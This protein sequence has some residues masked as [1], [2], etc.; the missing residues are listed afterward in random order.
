[1]FTRR[2][3]NNHSRHPNR[4]ARSSTAKKLQEFV[5]PFKPDYDVSKLVRI[6]HTREIADDD[7]ETTKQTIYIPQLPEDATPYQMLD[8]FRE[9]DDACETMTWTTG[10]AKFMKIKPH[11]QGIHKEVWNE[12]LDAVDGRSNDAF[13]EA[14]GIF[15]SETF[16]EVRDYDIQID[17]LRSIK[18]PGEMSVKCFLK[19]LKIANKQVKM[20]PGAPDDGGLTESEL[21]KTFLQAMPRQ[22]QAHYKNAGRIYHTDNI[23]SMRSYFD[24]QEADDPYVARSND[25][26]APSQ[27]GNNHH[28]PERN[29]FG[30]G[31]NNRNGRR[32]NGNQRNPNNHQV[33]RGQQVGG[34]GNERCYNFGHQGNHTVRECRRMR[35]LLRTNDQPNRTAIAGNNNNN[36]RYNLRPRINESNAVETTF[37]S[38]NQPARQV[39]HQVANPNSG[40][41]HSFESAPDL[42]HMEV[43]DMEPELYGLFHNSDNNSNATPT[44]PA[45]DL[46]PVT[47]AT[48]RKVSEAQGNFLFKALLD[49]GGSHVMV[50][51]A[52][53]PRDT[54]LY[55]DDDEKS[56]RT[57]QG[58]F[59]PLG[60]VY[61]YDLALPEF[62]HTRRFDTVKAYVFDAP[63]RYDII[64][65][66][67]FLRMANMKLD[68][69]KNE[70]VWFENRVPFHDTTFLEDGD[71][72]RRALQVNPF[73]IQQATSY[74]GDSFYN[75]EGPLKA[76]DYQKV[77]IG[78][79]VA[80][81][82]HLSPAQR[83]DLSKLLTKFDKLFSGKIGHFKQ[84]TFKIELKPGTVPYHCKQPYAVPMIDR[85]IFKGELDR[86]VE[87]GLLEQVFDTEWGMPMFATKKS[88]GTIRTV[89]DLRKLNAAIKRVH[90]PL[91]KI[92]DIF[93]R[94][95]N[96]QFFTKIDI[97]MQYY[98]F[99]LDE[100]SSWYCVLVTPFGKYRRKVLPMGL[101]NSPDWAQA[102][103]EEIFR[104]ML[105]KVEVY[106]DDV[107]IFDNT[108]EEHLHT[109]EQ[110]LTRLQDHDFTVKPDKCEW[111]VRETSF[112]GFWL[113]PTGLKQWPR[114]V[115]AIMKLDKPKTLKQLRAFVG[116]VNFYRL[117][118][119][120]RAHIMA[121]LTDLTGLTKDQQRHFQRY[122]TAA[123]DKA[124]EDTKKMV[125]KETLLKY[126]DPN[127][128]FVVETD[129]SDKQIGA[130]ILQEGSPVAFYSRKLTGPQSRYPIPDKEAL[131]IV[132]VLT[133]FRSLLLGA[134]ITV[135]TDHMNIT[136]DNITSQ[137]LLNWRLLIEE[138]APTLQ[139]VQGDSN[140]GADM[141]SRY[142]LLEEKQEAPMP[143]LGTSTKHNLTK[144]EF[145][146]EDIT[147]IMLYYPEEIERFPLNFEDIRKAQQSDAEVLMLLN[148]Q[149]YKVE[150]FYGTQLVC[151][152]DDDKTKIILPDGMMQS[153]IEWYHY[154]CGHVG[155]DRLYKSLSLFFYNRGMK[156]K[157]EAYVSTCDSCQ[158]NKS[159]GPGYAELPPRIATEVPFEQVAVDLIGPWKIDIPGYGLLKFKALT[160]IDQATTLSELVRIDTKTSANI[161][162]QFE[163]HWL[164][165]YPRPMSCIYD[166]G[167]EFIGAP[168]QQCLRRNGIESAPSSVKNPQ[169]NAVCE[170]LHATIGD[171]L[172]SMMHEN[173]PTNVSQAYEM[174]DT[175]L[176]S[177]QFAVRASVHR[178]MGLSPGAIVF[179]RDMFHPIP[180]LVNYNDL[181]ERRQQV[182][183]YNNRRANYRRRF[184][185]YQPGQEVLV[186]TYQPDKMEPR[187]TGPFKIA[188]VHVNGTV[189][190]KRSANVT[191][192]INVRRIRP[193]H[194]AP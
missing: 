26:S 164:A 79:V 23:T 101:A 178:T 81:Q 158:R 146:N 136:R 7:D 56:F 73:R 97:S 76:A 9:F 161:T 169:S 144:D 99:H 137:R 58:T 155:I 59:K 172:R 175:A 93:E 150:E 183:D 105:H 103:M 184:Q 72:I 50:R 129:A 46:I 77:D 84:R 57:T 188:T 44:E 95:R 117:F 20:I 49:T 194:R 114:K 156:G 139:Y 31:R 3:S 142:P 2:Q 35:Q 14:R 171:I 32:H 38:H 119:K 60:F 165:R 89:D 151:K 52:A 174:V 179:Q 19:Y 177:A 107:G 147:E 120:R 140:I 54:Q 37:H 130:V 80:Q 29:S 6:K 135:K 189:T 182:I 39:H 11:L 193:Y 102:T 94:R 36:T 116:M 160:I 126:P 110:V 154:V 113:T 66:R 47:L 90:Y 191:E 69:Y 190:I 86:Q 17:Y 159:L 21:K 153:T 109:V 24:G 15:L 143:S 176:A 45:T 91:P 121:P 64:L 70:T 74:T 27:P 192:R 112:L 133:V 67:N 63:A 132:E 1:M 4:G 166:P 170:R 78:D 62:S 118:H 83:D 134:D 43:D 13:K 167:S 34:N 42:Y 22:W 123:H 96:Y 16:E 48:A 138:F 10:A 61:L 168:F 25:S 75:V 71:N 124:F 122:W 68:F 104:D 65:G 40:E 180:L 100:E 141:L 186:L 185:D 163:N 181:R 108:W 82:H 125:A 8:F 111:A 5:I 127:K 162:M 128:P 115:E 148:Q 187:A 85:Q 98:C 157:I 131:S 173:P 88:N 149:G 18:K 87:L 30:N 12:T 145:E 152:V 41:N 51:K 92:Q 33:P 106:L 55:S 28:G 53:L